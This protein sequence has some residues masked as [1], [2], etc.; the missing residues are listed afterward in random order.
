ME[1]D[2]VNE[3]KFGEEVLS[4]METQIGVGKKGY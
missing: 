4:G 1:N 2:R 3:G